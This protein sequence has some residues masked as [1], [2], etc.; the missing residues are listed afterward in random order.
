MDCCCSFVSV[1]VV[2]L[3][4]TVIETIVE[5]EIMIDTVRNANSSSGS[6]S[7][8]SNSSGDGG[9]GSNGSSPL[10]LTPQLLNSMVIYSWRY[11]SFPVQALMHIGRYCVCATIGHNY[12]SG[13]F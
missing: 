6:G 10:T 7:G 4:E 2:T 8:S 3:G 13:Q 11:P 1:A 12:I 5:I 9:S